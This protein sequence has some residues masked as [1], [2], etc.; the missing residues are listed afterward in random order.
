MGIAKVLRLPARQRHQPSLG[1]P[2]DRRFP[3]GARAIVERGHRAFRHSALD[4]ALDRLM[5][6][7]ER[8]TYRKKRR[9]F[10]IGLAG[11][12]RDCAIDLNFAVS[13]SP[14]DNSIA[15]RHAAMTPYPLILGTRDLNR[16][17]KTQMNPPLMTT[18]MESLR[19]EQFFEIDLAAV[20][21]IPG[22]DDGLFKFTREEQV[23]HLID[24]ESRDRRPVRLPRCTL[25]SLDPLP[26]AGPRS[27]SSGSSF[28]MVRAS[29]MT[30][31]QDK[32]ST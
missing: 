27:L 6:Q 20:L 22:H 19:P 2:R 28:W 21:G 8:P 32:S 16:C 7:P 18:F 13:E 30:S 17:S 12:V 26:G 14:S 4:A 25:A 9:V 23:V 11:S 1:L 31:R 29:R 24:S 15:R 3:A 10:P 5:M